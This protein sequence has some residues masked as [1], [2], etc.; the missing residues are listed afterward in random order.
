MLGVR[1]ISRQNI[2]FQQREIAQPGKLEFFEVLLGI[3]EVSDH[4]C[5]A[6][7]LED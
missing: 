1:R 5:A 7:T 4:N 3:L 2:E 6:D